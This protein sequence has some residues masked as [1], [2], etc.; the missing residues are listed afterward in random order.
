M[1]RCRG[2]DFHCLFNDMHTP[3]GYSL[4]VEPSRNPFAR[5]VFA[6]HPGRPG[7]PSD[8]G[9]TNCPL[10]IDA[11]VVALLPQFPAQCGDLAQGIGVKR[12]AGPG[13]CVYQVNAVDTQQRA[14]PGLNRPTE[15]PV[16]MGLAE[17]GHRRQ[18]M[19]NVAHRAQPHDQDAGLLSVL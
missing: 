10:Q 6:N 5:M 12:R 15:I 14:P 7:K 19:Q 11:Q 18:G 4:A 3:G 8:D 13:F 9:G 16:W 1:T 17:C 2:A